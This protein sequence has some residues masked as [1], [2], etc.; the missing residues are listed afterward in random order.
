MKEK[1]GE[2]EV[3]REIKY[4]GVQRARE[5]IINIEERMR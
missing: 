4:R 3:E 1:I 2:R 5:K